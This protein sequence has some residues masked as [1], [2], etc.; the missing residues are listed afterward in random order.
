I[1]AQVSRTATADYDT[2]GKYQK[3]AQAVTAAMQ[4]LAGG[5]LAQA[6]SGAVSPYV[7]EIIHSQTTDSAT[8][9][10]NVEANA[11]AHAVW[12]AIAAA[13]GNNSALAGAAGAVSGELL[14]RWIAAE[15]YPDVK[16][17]ELSD[18][19]KST[20]SALSTLAAGLMGG[21][22][23]GSSADAVA[24]AQAGKNAVENNALSDIAE[25]LAS[26]QS[27]AEKLDKLNK[28]EEERFSREECAGLSPDACGAKMYDHRR[29]ALKDM[30]S[31][32]VDFL[33]IA[34][35]IK[36][37]AEAESA[38]DYLAAVIGIFPGLGDGAGKAIKAAEKALAKGD[39]ES[40]SKLINKA[41][42]DIQ[43]KWVDENA[44]MSQRARD[45]NDSATG[46]RSNIDTQKGQAPT[47]DRIDANGNSKPVR[48]DGVDGNV[49]I[50][51]KISVVTTQKAKN[52]ALRQSEALKNS[53][54]TGRWEVPNQTQAN[55]AQK[56][57][58]D[59]GIKNI[60]VKI[61][62]E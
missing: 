43:V 33:P 59:L 13:S 18:E 42:D 12:G 36:G 61:V 1:S 25:Q 19:Q 38:I 24:G 28:A 3:V 17:E 11:M 32:G 31:L 15:Y 10:V 37:F 8:G 5:N 47:I 41:S 27:P 52:Q 6:A 20:I 34:G 29:E 45:Y 46:A 58:D 54:I 21:L 23:G 49:M 22:S 2:G 53:G 30:A 4:G 7:A 57:F 48:F 62:K 35:D 55:R 50:D 60:E 51:R 26:G 14:G 16:T 39:L 56:M 40:A 44:G 9:K